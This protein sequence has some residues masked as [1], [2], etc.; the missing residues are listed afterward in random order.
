[1]SEYSDV[2]KKAYE[3]YNPAIITRYCFELAKA[4]NDFYNK[5]SILSAENNDLIEARL[6]LIGLVKQVLEDALE[7][8]TIDTVEKM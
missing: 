3:N 2:V 8:L 5:H 7:L 6:I 1:M 4:F